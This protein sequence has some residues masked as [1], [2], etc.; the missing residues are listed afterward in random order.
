MARSLSPLFCIS[1]APVSKGECTLGI[2]SDRLVVIRDGPV[3][4]V[5][6]RISVA[7]AFEGDCA[8]RIE[9]DGLVVSGDGLM[10]GARVGICIALANQSRIACSRLSFSSFAL[11]LRPE[12]SDS[13]LLGLC[14]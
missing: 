1:D 9:S 5:F 14:A 8:C 13:L 2:E 3:V 4:V 6:V 10:I 11:L 7:P 12:C